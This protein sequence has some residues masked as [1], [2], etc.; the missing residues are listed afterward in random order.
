MREGGVYAGG[1]SGSGNYV[2]PVRAGQIQP[3]GCSVW[4]DVIARYQAYVNGQAAWIDV[5]TC[6]TQYTSP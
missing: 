3:T 2:W 5:I 6:Y 4:S 1:K